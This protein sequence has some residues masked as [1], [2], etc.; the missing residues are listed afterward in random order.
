MASNWPKDEVERLTRELQ[1]LNEEMS[2]TS[3]RGRPVY[4]R[5][6]DNSPCDSPTQLDH[7]DPAA[8]STEK[9]APSETR[10]T[11]RKEIEARRYNGKEPITEYLLQFELTA[12]RNG[13]AESEKATNLLCALDGPARSVL[14]EVDIDKITYKQVKDLLVKRFGPVLLTEIHE[15][16]LQDLRL[17]KHQSIR[18]LTTEVSRLTKLAYPEFNIAARERFAVKALVNAINDKDTIFYIKEK[19]PQSVDEVCVL[20]ER[21]KVLTG[22]SAA[23]RPPAVKGVK[24]ADESDPNPAVELLV[25]QTEAHSR[26]LTQLAESINKLIQQQQRQQQPAACELPHPPESNPGHSS[27]HPR[28]DVPRKPCPR[29]KQSGHWLKDC[30]QVETCFRCGEPGHRRSDC[31]MPLNLNGPT[32]APH[33]GPQAPRPY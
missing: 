30:T 12:K 26:Q 3:F 15:Q 22:N 6:R 13:W 2:A 33:A 24:T 16:A 20:Y 31:R 21:F 27:G 4:G 23:C 29:C 17:A 32:S 11:K 8:S 18:E 9:R 19:N 28:A 14:A 1:A 7:F 5:G 25:K 10:S